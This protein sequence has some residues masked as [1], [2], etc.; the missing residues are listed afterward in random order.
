MQTAPL[1]SDRRKN[2]EQVTFREVTREELEN[3]R[4]GQHFYFIARDRKAREVRI[5]SRVDKHP[6]ARRTEVSVK[7]GMYESARIVWN[8]DENEPCF[9]PMLFVRA[10]V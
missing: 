10:S 5:S 3:A 2:P 4:Y 7:F 6:R 9:G 8:W 1:A